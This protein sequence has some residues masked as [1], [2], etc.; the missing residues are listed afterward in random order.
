MKP[1]CLATEIEIPDAMCPVTIWSDWSPCS[2]TCGNGVR[3]RTRLLLVEE[4]LKAECS[5]RLELHQQEQCSQKQSCVINRAE[6]AG[7]YDAVVYSYVLE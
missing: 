6:A 1:E 7:N 2:A 5:T 4:A 3:I